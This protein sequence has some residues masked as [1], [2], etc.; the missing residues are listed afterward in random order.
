MKVQRVGDYSITR[1]AEIESM[2]LDP[3]FLFG[4]ITPEII[5]A[6]RDWIG[7]RCIEPGTDKVILSFHTYVV[8]TKHHTILVDTCNGNDKSR[9]SMMAWDHLNLPFLETLAKHGVTQDKVDYVMCTHLH[10]DHVGWNTQLKNGKWVPTFPNAK[11]LM[12]RTEFD[13]FNKVHRSNPPQ[14]VNRGSFVDSVLPIVEQG[15]A[16]MVDTDYVFEGEPGNGIWLEHAPGHTPGGVSVRVGAKGGANKGL[17]VMSGDI[18][19]HP[20][21]FAEPTLSNPADVD[22]ALAVTTKLKLMNECA[23]SD[24]VLLT[25][26]FPDPTACKVLRHGERFRFRFQED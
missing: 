18:I 5:A 17:A 25:G 15:R 9:P 13:H 7:P 4:I 23:D 21:Q 10:T 3:K 16:V 14:P 26:H 2:A 8:R 12:A 22:P 20:L 1:V 6:N 24:L 19:H 11:Y